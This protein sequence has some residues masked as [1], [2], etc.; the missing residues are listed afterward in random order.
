MN[1]FFGVALACEDLGHMSH[2]H[3]WQS[4][5]PE[6]EVE[7]SK[8]I[9]DKHADEEDL[10]YNIGWTS[11]VEIQRLRL[12]LEEDPNFE[13]SSDWPMVVEWCSSCSLI[14]LV[15]MVL[16]PVVKEE[17]MEV[18]VKEE[19]I[20]AKFEVDEVKLSCEATA[21]DACTQTPRRMRRGGRGSRM[22]RLLAFQLMLSQRKGLPLSRLLKPK[23][24]DTMYSTRLNE[25]SSQV[26][27]E[28]EMKIK[29]KEEKEVGA[30]EEVLSSGSTNS[31]LRS[32]PTEANQPSNQT[33]PSSKP[34]STG[35]GISPFSVPPPPFFTPPSMP[36][37]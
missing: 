28:K 3:Q 26:K 18:L 23:E 33:L 36:S 30:R 16:P 34:H 25:K 22:K 17:E 7:W 13:D 31:T 19:N 1:D 15:K 32:F 12:L 6:G 5:P 20:L 29:V 21:R 14:R 35:P 11:P 2:V 27:V 37:F 10:A 4:K 9:E 8:S 24:T